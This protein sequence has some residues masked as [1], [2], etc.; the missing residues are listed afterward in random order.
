MKWWILIQWHSYHSHKLYTS[1]QSPLSPQSLPSESSQCSHHPH[2]YSQSFTLISDTASKCCC[3]RTMKCSPI[4]VLFSAHPDAPS[5]SALAVGCVNDHASWMYGFRVSPI[6]TDVLR[7]RLQSCSGFIAVIVPPLPRCARVRSFFLLP[8][9]ELHANFRKYFCVRNNAPLSHYGGQSAHPSLSS[10]WSFYV[11]L[12]MD[13]FAHF[14]FSLLMISV[15]DNFLWQ[16]DS[17]SHS[18]RE[19]HFILL[20]LVCNGTSTPHL[21]MVWRH[22]FIL[23]QQAVNGTTFAHNFVWG[24][25]S[26]L[27]STKT[28]RLLLFYPCVAGFLPYPVVH[29]PPSS[30][31]ADDQYS[32]QHSLYGKR[33]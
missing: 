5:D 21:R 6:Q 23:P 2:P 27:Y 14:S 25:Y 19:T 7:R 26:L 33:N 20:F 3:T 4:D 13:G 15:R 9:D 11:S 24:T 10:L 8:A 28:I 18:T 29:S 16:T 22:A 32:L 17:T 31:Y 12:I 1:P 30:F